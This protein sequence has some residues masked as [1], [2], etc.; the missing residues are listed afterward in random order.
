MA[1]TYITAT[2]KGFST[3]ERQNLLGM[4]RYEP[5]FR[6]YN[7]VCVVMGKREDRYRLEDM[8]EYDKVFVASPPKPKSEANSSEVGALKNSQKWLLWPN[9]QFW[10]IQP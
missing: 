8:V 9:Q 1:I 10:N 4:K 2:K 3:A 5:V 7:K 6:M